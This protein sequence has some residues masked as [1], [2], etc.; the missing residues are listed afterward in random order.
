MVRKS[1]ALSFTHQSDINSHQQPLS[2]K[3][4]LIR[5]T[6]RKASSVGVP[7]TMCNGGSCGRHHWGWG[8]SLG[9]VPCNGMAE[10]KYR[11]HSN[12]SERE[13]Y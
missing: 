1:T 2:W 10:L 7:T 8:G 9:T 11:Q 5:F 12:S 6:I 3:A 13:S 4:V